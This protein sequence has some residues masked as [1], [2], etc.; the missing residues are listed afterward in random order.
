[1][2]S[3]RVAGVF[4]VLTLLA[5]AQE[6]P[7]AAPAS[8]ESLASLRLSNATVTSASEVAA[9]GFTPPTAPGRGVAPALARAVAALP[10]LCRVALTS[11]PTAD[12]DITIEVWLP[13]SG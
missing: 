11:K 2:Q 9:G 3:P 1:M 12:S 7:A 6:R 13:A 5:P 10:A 8:C 4:V